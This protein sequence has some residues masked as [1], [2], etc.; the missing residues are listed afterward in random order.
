MI[1]V[2]LTCVALILI[3]SGPVWASCLAS[4]GGENGDIIYNSDNKVFQ[5]C[6]DMDWIAMHSPGSGTGGCSNPAAPEGSLFFNKDYRVLQGCAGSVWHAMG[7]IKA[8]APMNGLIGFWTFDEDGGTVAADSSGN[9]LN[10]TLVGGP[11]W[12]PAG[13]IQ[14]GALLFDGMD[15]RVN[16]VDPGTGSLLDFSTGTSI[17][18]TAWIRQTNVGGCCQSIVAKGAVG[19]ANYYFVVE[20][21]GG[22]GATLDFGFYN[23]GYREIYGDPNLIQNNVWKFVAVSYRFGTGPGALYVN[24]VSAGLNLLN[25]PYPRSPIVNNQTLTFGADTAGDFWYAGLIDN[26]R[27]YDRVLSAAEIMQIY[28]VIP[29]NNRMFL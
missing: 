27:I 25:D 10:G 5:Y 9:G 21:L 22:G 24:G 26:I 19:S 18:I 6:S 7:P 14:G 13:G 4:P 2:T 17:T 3:L 15:D 16:V 11:V 20:N 29:N 23:G 12:Q 1:R 28:I 8:A